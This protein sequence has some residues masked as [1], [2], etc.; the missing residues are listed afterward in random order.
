[1]SQNCL[2]ATTLLDYM[3]PSIQSLIAERGWQRLSDYDK[4]GASYDF[5]RNEILFG[6]N[7]DDSLP[8]SKVFADGYGQCNTKGTLLMALLRGLGIPCRFHGFTIDKSLQRGVVPELVYPIAPRN[9]IH[10]WVEVFHEGEWLNL[11][12]F[13][14]DAKILGALQ[15]HFPERTSLCAY[16]AGT[17]CLPSP[18]VEWKGASTYIQRA[19]INSDFG[20]FDSPDEFYKDHH[21]LSGLRGALY[22]YIVRHWMNH[23]VAKMRHGRIPTI[24]G[25]ERALMPS[26]SAQQFEEVSS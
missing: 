11:E 23:R 5:V 4:I 15:N 17:D 14:L 6:Y 12:G 24:P 19:G 7:A 25:G 16:G 20:T 22:R 1:M 2:A 13:I 26:V 8:A 3:T 10:S 18:D 9:I 21:Q